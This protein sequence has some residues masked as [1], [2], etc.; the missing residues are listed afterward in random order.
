MEALFL[1]LC[2]LTFPVVL[3][4]CA[5]ASDYATYI[6]DAY[7]YQVTAITTDA[8]GNTYVTGS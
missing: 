8:S 2:I 3:A 4:F 7:K 5:N 1:R 6:G